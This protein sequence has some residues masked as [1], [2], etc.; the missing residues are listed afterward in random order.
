MKAQKIKDL[1]QLFLQNGIEIWLDGGWGVDALLGKQ[2]RLHGDV[3]IVIQEIDIQKLQLLL[4]DQ[5]Y[6]EMIRDD[7]STWNFVMG[8]LEGNLIDVHVIN[9]DAEGNG[10][11]GPIEKG[12][13]YPAYA[14]KGTGFIE[15]YPVKCLSAE[16]QVESH[17]GYQIDENDI[18]DVTALCEKFGIKYP[19]EY[20]TNI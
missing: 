7:S 14:F 3:D 19:R 20:L 4:S 8:D 12:V 6:A 13:E 16:Y 5:G 15:D 18:K 9:F 10:D 17:T 11:Y 2:T 1:H